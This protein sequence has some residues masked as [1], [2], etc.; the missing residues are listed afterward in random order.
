MLRVSKVEGWLA[1][2]RYAESLVPDLRNEGDC[3]IIRSSGHLAGNR[4]PFHPEVLPAHQASVPLAGDEGCRR[5]D[6]EARPGGSG[7]SA[8]ALS[9]RLH[10]VMV[11]PGTR[12]TPHFHAG[13]ETS[14]YVVSGQAEVW[15]GTGLVKRS[16]VRAGDVIHVPPG[17][18]HLA[19]N[20]GDVTTITVVA[21]ADPPDSDG[22]VMIELPR[23]LVGLACIPV[24]SGA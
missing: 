2:Q 7:P 23:H 1:R 12:S 21:R 13:R 24:G 9:L 6:G 8:G 18:P 5:S 22:A 3:Q 19:V 20:R 15:H 4:S 14:V 11:P 16:L 17:A 10:L